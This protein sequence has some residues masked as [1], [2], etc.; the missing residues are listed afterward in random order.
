[1]KKVEGGD[2]MNHAC[3]MSHRCCFHDEFKYLFRE[4][5]FPKRRLSL[6][7]HKTALKTKYIILFSRLN[8]NFCVRHITS[9]SPSAASTIQNSSPSDHRR[10]NF[11]VVFEVE[12]LS[13][14]L[15]ISHQLLMGRQ[16]RYRHHEQVSRYL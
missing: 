1:V 5:Q 6:R 10:A 9:K 16:L 8:A 2:G 4:I 15:P 11:D 13:C 14:K 3:V 7:C 12:L